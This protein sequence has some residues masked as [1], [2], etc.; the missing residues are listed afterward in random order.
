M[1]KIHATAVQKYAQ[2]SADNMSDVAL[3]TVLSIRQP[4]LNIGFQLKDVRDNRSEAKSLWG[5]KKKTY[6][7]TI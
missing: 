5:G 6:Q 2:E 7:F 3:M 4:W 1:Y